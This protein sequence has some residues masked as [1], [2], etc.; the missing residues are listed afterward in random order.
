MATVRIMM[1]LDEFLTRR[2][3]GT[4]APM[5]GDPD[6][7]DLRRT[8]REF[9]D[10]RRQRPGRGWRWSRRWPPT[11]CSARGQAARRAGAAST[12]LR[13]SRRIS[14]RKAKNCIFIF[15]EGAPSQI[16]LF[17]PKPKLNELHGQTLPE[18]LIKNVRFAFIKKETAALLGSQAQVHQARPVRHGASDLLPHL[19]HVRRR[20]AAGPL[21]CTPT[22]SIII[23]A[24]C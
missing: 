24:S 1:N 11:A 12:R 23:P 22:S 9:L 18:S 10:Q 15:L 17:D 3:R 2:M 14:R 16:D 21:A 19:G 4:N 13:P 20:H 5:H 7:N 6:R 8:R